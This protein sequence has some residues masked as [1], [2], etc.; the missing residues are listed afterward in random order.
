MVLGI[1]S[2]G[3]VGWDLPLFSPKVWSMIIMGKALCLCAQGAFGGCCSPTT[4]KAALLLHSSKPWVPS[5]AMS[6][7]GSK[8]SPKH[9]CLALAPSPCCK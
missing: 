4:D 8:H 5:P 2:Y 7:G 9:S 6:M 3:E 1:R